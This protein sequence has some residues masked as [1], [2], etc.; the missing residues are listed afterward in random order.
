M[1]YESNIDILTIYLPER[2]ET[3]NASEI[4][5]EITSVINSNPHEKLVFDASGLIYISSAGLR[6]FMKIGRIN[7]NSLSIIEVSNDIYSIFETTGF[8]EIFNIKKK[9]R[10]LDVTGCEI[11][12]KGFYGT[13]YRLDED[14]IVKVYDSPDSI[15]MIENE[16][17]MAKMAFLKGIPTA[18][19]Y[20]I[21]RVGNSYGSVFELLNAKTFNDLIIEDPD[22]ID[23]TIDT[24]TD[25]IKSI[26]QTEMDEGT[27]PS[28][29]EV[30]LGYLD[31]IR[32]YIG[33]DLAAKLADLFKSMPKDLHVVHGDCQM[34]NV[35]MVDNEPMIIDMD[36]LSVGHPIFDLMALYVTYK[37]FPEDEE[38]NAMNFL[39]IPKE[40]VDHMWDRILHRYLSDRDEDAVQEALKKI[41]VGAC[42]RFLFIIAVSDLKN[43]ELGATRIRH[44]VEYLKETLPTVDTLVF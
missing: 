19:S 15:P 16:K 23:K 22:N 3:A 4:E 13:V 36:T 33:D 26:H 10:T 18:I 28:S 35:M 34:K 27:L 32:E 2:I 43:S 17:K 25:F 1:N 7:G 30:F 8:T 41:H 42:V 31:V 14:T 24:Y 11:I 12:G 6:A 5:A 40:T 20:D 37:A 38:E 44:T 9:L 21:V 39:G 29:A